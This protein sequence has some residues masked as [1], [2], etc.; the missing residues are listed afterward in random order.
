MDGFRFDQL[1]YLATK[2]IFKF[3]RLRD[4]ATC[5]AVSRQFKFYSDEAEV[6]RL[7]VKDRGEGFG[8]WH[9]TKRPIDFKDAISWKQF[10]ALK[11]SQFKL[12][13]QLR[14]L[15][16]RLDRTFSFQT[17]NGFKQLA[18]LELNLMTSDRR[19]RTL[20]L[21]ELRVLKLNCFRNSCLLK[22]PKLEVLC[23]DHIADLRFECPETI[24]RLESDYVGADFMGR[25][26]NLE[27]FK[28]RNK[29]VGLDPNLLSAWKNLREFDIV[30]R[31]L[32]LNSAKVFRRSLTAILR[33][34]KMLK[35]E[36]LKCYL[37]DVQLM[38]ESQLDNYD[39]VRSRSKF[40]LKNHKLL[41]CSY[42]GLVA[43]VRRPS[44]P[45]ISSTN[46]LAFDWL[47]LLARSTEMSSSGS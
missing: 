20:T 31:C 41:R 9:L 29:I 11:P 12:N 33:E 4:L 23:C 34:R 10:L 19:T 27:V 18:H 37:D 25:F 17:L 13:Q 40:R 8:C 35:R 45:A 47:K 5:R 39:P 30:D 21:P 28:V 42:H 16:I 44:C 46:F 43:S 15:H 26:S 24:K 6:H 38:D 22:T 14:S 36:E 7:V 2:H 3:L 32:Y 1:P